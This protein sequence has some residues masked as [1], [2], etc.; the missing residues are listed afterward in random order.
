M[1]PSMQIF[2]PEMKPAL[3]EHRNSTIFAMSIGLPQ[4]QNL[5]GGITSS[6]SAILVQLLH[7]AG[8]NLT[9]SVF[10]VQILTDFLDRLISLAAVLYLIRFI[11]AD[12]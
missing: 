8:V 9:V 1:P 5:F 11:P 7:L 10:L 6:G 3:S 2:S 4:L 12:L